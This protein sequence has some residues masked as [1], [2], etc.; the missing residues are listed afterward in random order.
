MATAGQI[1]NTFMHV[2]DIMPTI[3]EMASVDYPETFQGRE[4]VPPTGKSGLAYVQGNAETVHGPDHGQ[5]WELFEMKAYIKGEW[6]IL[7]LPAPFD[8]GGWA[9]YNLT[10]DP[11]ETIDLSDQFPEIKQELLNGWEDYVRT[12]NVF[13]HNGH[14][15]SLY[16][17]A[18]QA[19]NH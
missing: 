7:R 14:F 16:L 10:K 4:V 1:K 12:N 5:G 11:G 15:D 18:S 13:D 9:L 17:R 2:S 6:K 19:I 3:F 8:D